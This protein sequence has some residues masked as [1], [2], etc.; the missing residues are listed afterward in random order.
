MKKLDHSQAERSCT[1]F[2]VAS[3][4]DDIVDEWMLF[5]EESNEEVVKDVVDF[6]LLDTLIQITK[7][8]SIKYIK[9]LLWWEMNGTK[10]PI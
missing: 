4:E 10:Y 7:K 9:V 3:T 5:V 6:Y 1:S 2:D 8:E